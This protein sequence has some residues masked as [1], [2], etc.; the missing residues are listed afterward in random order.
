MS[1]L[2]AVDG[3]DGR[4][5]ALT[6]GTKT[7]EYGSLEPPALTDAFLEKLV[8]LCASRTQRRPQT[9]NLSTV[10]PVGFSRRRQS[11]VN[12]DAVLLPDPAADPGAT[13]NSD[14]DGGGGDEEE[15][16]GADDGFAA[17]TARGATAP[18]QRRAPE[19]LTPE[20]ARA[21]ESV[22]GSNPPD[23]L[24]DLEACMAR[25]RRDIA[26][27]DRRTIGTLLRADSSSGSLRERLRSVLAEMQKLAD[28][29][30]GL[31]DVVRSVQEG[32]NEM[33]Q[34]HAIMTQQENNRCVRARVRACVRADA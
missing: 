7:L 30:S 31:D 33:Q 19:D 28:H 24:T 12:L 10:R 29:I 14:G 21:L 2:E 27:R 20:E 6:F 16:G 11:Q 1:D 4:S 9:R 15:D 8:D 18:S 13:G 25:L 22:L 3:R 5:F 34:T 23:D 32:Y 17:D 26:A